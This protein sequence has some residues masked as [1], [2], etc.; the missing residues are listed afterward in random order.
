VVRRQADRQAGIF[1]PVSGRSPGPGFGVPRNPYRL[2]VPAQAIAFRGDR[3]GARREEYG[4]APRDAFRQGSGSF[5]PRRKITCPA[6]IGQSRGRGN[7]QGD[8]GNSALPPVKGALLPASSSM[9]AC[10]LRQP[11][12]RAR[13]GRSSAKSVGIGTLHASRVSVRSPRPCDGKKHPA[14]RRRRRCPYLRGPCGPTPRAGTPT[15]VGRKRLS[16]ADPH[17]FTPRPRAP[18]RR[19]KAHR[20]DDERKGRRVDGLIPPGSVQPVTPRSSIRAGTA[21]KLD[22]SGSRSTPPP[23]RR[24]L[25]LHIRLSGLGLGPVPVTLRPDLTPSYAP[26]FPGTR[27]G[28]PYAINRQSTTYRK[29]GGDL[30]GGRGKLA[31]TC[32]SSFRAVLR[33]HARSRHGRAPSPAASEDVLL[34]PIGLLA[35]RHDHRELVITPQTSLPALAVHGTQPARRPVDARDCRGSDIAAA[36]IA[37]EWCGRF[38]GPTGKLPGRSRGNGGCG[39]RAARQDRHPFGC[40]SG[41]SRNRLA[42]VGYVSELGSPSDAGQ[43]GRVDRTAAGTS[44]R[45]RKLAETRRRRR[46]AFLGQGA[47][48]KNRDPTSVSK[49]ALG[50]DVGAARPA[51]NRGRRG[52]VSRCRAPPLGLPQPVGIDSEAD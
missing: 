19:Q 29:F 38:S 2:R 26:E 35:R 32:P 39:S 22:G 30:R 41:G 20:R 14:V 3:D 24:C 40:S 12:G 10:S 27:S 44:R 31:A 21:S 33:R 50:K 46:G 16:A 47:D 42:P 18:P 1:G 13:A 5:T 28:T 43:P 4:A 36:A 48:P 17:R 6:R 8:R 37:R 15:T 23:A 11:R 52:S 7:G 34:D 49:R 51:S 9:P 45:S 25:Y